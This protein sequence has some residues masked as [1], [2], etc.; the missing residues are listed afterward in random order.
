MEGCLGGEPARLDRVVDALQPRDV[1]EARA[2]ADEEQPRRAQLPREGVVAA[3]R[4][5]LRAPGDP[6]ASADDVPDEPVRL[7]LLEDVVDRELDVARLQ[8]RHEADRDEI[9]THRVDEG[10][11]ELAVARKRS[12]RPAHRVH[13]LPQR[14]RDTPD[15][16]DAER[17]DLRVLALQPEALD[18]GGREKTLRS[19]G[20]N[21]DAGDHVRAALEGRQWLAVP[22][23]ALVAPARAQDAAVGDEQLHRGGLGKHDDAE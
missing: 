1:D 20:K 23:T 21:R 8:P 3:L 10:A 17:P 4:D 7:E 16:L 14:A 11:T 15:L 2:L 12:Q 18:R 9:V 19:L 22:P 5:R 13:D 6:L